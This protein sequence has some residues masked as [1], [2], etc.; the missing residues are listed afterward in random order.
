MMTFR[1][2]F[3]AES[4]CGEV[5]QSPPSRRKALG[6][7]ACCGRLALDELAI[8]LLDHDRGGSPGAGVRALGGR[9]SGCDREDD[10]QAGEYE[11]E[12]PLHMTSTSY[13]LK[14]VRPLF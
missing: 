7:A 13:G 5:G 2:G 3:L 11:H 12:G 10:Q 14:R 9:G 8:D 1:R 6:D 4:V